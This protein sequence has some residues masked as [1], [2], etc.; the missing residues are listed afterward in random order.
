MESIQ[1]F[2]KL[3][4]DYDQWFDANSYAYKSEILAVQKFIPKYSHTLEIGVGTGRFA[5]PFNIKVGVEPAK[6]MADI[7]RRRGIE[8]HNAKAEELPFADGSF[9][10]VLMVTVIC[11]FQNPIQSLKEAQR[12]LKPGGRLVIGM[13]DKDSPVG[14]IYELKK[15]EN[16]FYRQANFYSIGQV[17]EW[18][19][20]LGFGQ[21]KICQTI[22]KNPVGLTA[23]EPVKDG[24]GEGVFVVIAVENS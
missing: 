7:A 3:A 24:Y 15:N 19:T 12:V 14:R 18:L 22:F 5:V 10:L 23:I 13:I 20:E 6:A 11:F 8:V 21:P 9:D 4:V 16:E 2:E 17:M 1:V